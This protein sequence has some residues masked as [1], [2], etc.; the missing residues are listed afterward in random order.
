MIFFCLQN[1]FKKIVSSKN[2]TIQKRAK[3]VLPPKNFSKNFVLQGYLKKICV[4]KIEEIYHYN[5]RIKFL[6]VIGR[7]ILPKEM[8]QLN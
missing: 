1:F 6:S 4:Q 7:K 5:Y 2:F 3:M 8:S